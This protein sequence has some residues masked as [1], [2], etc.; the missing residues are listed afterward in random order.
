[1]KDAHQSVL[2]SLLNENCLYKCITYKKKFIKLYFD[3]VSQ[4]FLILSTNEKKNVDKIRTRQ[5]EPMVRNYKNML[6]IKLKKK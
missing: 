5:I 1:M 4:I 6:E 3:F 2:L